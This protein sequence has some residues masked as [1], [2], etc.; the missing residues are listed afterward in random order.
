MRDTQ[1]KYKIIG[2]IGP[3]GCGKDTIKKSILKNTNYQG[4][5]TA[6]TRPKREKEKDGI[7]YLFL[8]EEDFTKAVLNGDMLEAENFNGWYYGTMTMSL[9]PEK[10]N[11]GIFSIDA[12]TSLL[13]HPDIDILPIY[14]DVSDKQRLLRVLNRE[15]TPDCSEICRRFLEDKKDFLDSDIKDFGMIVFKNNKKK[16]KYFLGES[17]VEY[18]NKKWS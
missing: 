16:F 12:Y 9:S 3:S 6:T 14:I 2:L 10:I 15:D 1:K 5:I 8:S 4:V 17:I 7:D 11:V 13:D 18:A